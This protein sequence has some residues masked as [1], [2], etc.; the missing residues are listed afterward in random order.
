MCFYGKP[1]RFKYGKSTS[2]FP[3]IVRGASR[4]PT[5]REGTGLDVGIVVPRS[6]CRLVRTLYSEADD[7][8]V[9]LEFGASSD[10]AE[11]T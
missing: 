7:G 8:K 4:Q 5:A 2:L 3:L 9:D 10:K 6:P 1:A 11:S